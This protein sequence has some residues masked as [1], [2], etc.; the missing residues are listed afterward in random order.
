MKRLEYTKI[1]IPSLIIR[2]LSNS[3]KNYC[4]VN[5][6]LKI[7]YLPFKCVKGVRRGKVKSPK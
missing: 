6:V 2:F 4:F 7:H 3:E 5:E 1:N